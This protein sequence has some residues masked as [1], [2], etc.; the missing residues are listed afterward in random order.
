M[1]ELR[2]LGS[3]E[4]S[5]LRPGAAAAVLRQPKRLALVA[6][7]C[8]VG[9]AGFVRRDVVLAMFWP[10]LDEA[11]ARPALR[12][13]LHFL[14][15]HLGDDVFATRGDD[16]AVAAERLR[17]DTALL[18]EALEGE[19]W[20]DAAA[21]Y[22]GPLLDG[23]HVAGADASFEDW[24]ARERARL[25]D[26]ARVAVDELGRAAEATG[27]PWVAV[28]WARRAVELDPAHEG[29]ARRLMRLLTERGDRS[30]ALATYAALAAR[31][32][33][34]HGVAPSRKT[35]AM[36][37]AARELGASAPNDSSREESAVNAEGSSGGPHARAPW[38]T[39]ARP[40]PAPVRVGLGDAQPESAHPSSSPDAAPRA[41]RTLRAAGPAP[42]TLSTGVRENLGSGDALLGRGR[43]LARLHEL[44][45]EHRLVTVTGPGGVGKTRVALHFA[46]DVLNAQPDGTWFVALAGVT[47]PEL[48]AT[49]I[50]GALGLT[51]AGERQAEGQVVEYLR[52]KRLLL[53]LDNFEQLVDAAPVVRAI[54]DEAPAVR[55]LVTSRERLNTSGERVLD[56]G[57]LAVPVVGDR[58]DAAAGVH[59]AIRLFEQ[60][61]AAADPEFRLTDDTW[62][63]VASICRSVGGLPLAVELAA[64]MLRGVACTELAAELTR[65][66]GALAAPLRDLP[67]RH[68]SL[69][70]VFEASWTRLAHDERAL[71]AALSTFCGGFTWDAARAV[72]G[73]SLPI[74]LALI[75]KSL[76]R[77]APSGRYDVHEVIREFAAQQLAI[78]SEVSTRLAQRHAA[79]FGT[80]LRDRESR[81][82]GEDLRGALDEIADEIAN[83]RAGWAW[84]VEHGAAAVGD[85]YVWS[86]ARFYDVRGW[87]DEGA[88]AFEFSERRDLTSPWVARALAQRAFFLMRR[89][90]TTE[91]RALL[92][93]SLYALRRL[94][95]EGD[96]VTPRKLLGVIAA[97][98]GRHRAAERLL[99]SAARTCRAAG[100]RFELAGCLNALGVVSMQA[101][102]YADAEQL[103]RESAVLRHAVG[104]QAGLASTLNNLGMVLNLQERPLEACEA[105]SECRRCADRVG[106]PLLAAS[107]LLNAADAYHHLGRLDDA[108]AHAA[109]S[110]RYFR[111]L[112]VATGVGACQVTLG[113]VEYRA[114]DDEQAARHYRH[115]AEVLEGVDD[116]VTQVTEVAMGY[117]AVLA[118]R[119][120]CGHAAALLALV[121]AH[122]ATNAWHSGRA[123]RLLAGLMPDD[124][125]AAGGRPGADR[126]GQQIALVDEGVDDLTL[127][128]ASMLRAG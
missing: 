30:G 5:G 35:A 95:A 17:A 80:F 2:L 85:A 14:R 68:Q 19:R 56:I 88:A 117:A 45:R 125:A 86:L 55:I 72:T 120:A 47:A 28:H 20:A 3:L 8:I 123:R 98:L 51:L 27:D 83:I 101:G 53:V 112:G 109:E 82:R 4:L 18:D 21:L 22:R 42:S 43:E 105:L 69:R 58:P 102:Q 119:G 50:A 97:S 128:I 90:R 52:A 67:A 61:A 44:L 74:L 79:Y 49:S 126:P 93:R 12:Q 106:N 75:D 16:L 26:G 11:R 33:Q 13:A 46:A 121:A 63:A 114:G 84:A 64:A 104:D 103:H 71:L 92:R 70:T 116:A 111:A 87:Y 113:E 115:A 10:D 96:T 110:E 40:A 37:D 1:I 73:S 41:G 107:A 57:G 100:D 108:R 29:A 99:Q 60:R 31:L 7:L 38:V 25:H 36:A 89:A 122:P 9:R 81:L 94:G 15:Q 6:F 65:D 118:R 34:E 48:L 24:L 59:D 124:E 54:L 91:A 23:F 39:D 77:R 78:E 66:V 76:V 32:R 62:P 127:T